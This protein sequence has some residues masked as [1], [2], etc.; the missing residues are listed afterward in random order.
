MDFYGINLKADVTADGT[1]DVGTALSPLGTIYGEVTAAQWGDLAE[2]YT[3]KEEC[4][5]GTVICVSRDP[6]FDVE[7][8]NDELS[9]SVIGAISTKPG[10]IMNSSL[11]GEFVALTGR[12][13]VKVIGPIYKGD[14]IVA[15]GNGC[16]RAGVLSDELVYKIGVAN[17]TNSDTGIKLVECV[18]K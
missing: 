17:E 15:A 14:F 11:V 1:P 4:E 7:P 3:C 13:P 6:K 16:A 10:L 8:C 9:M 18:I 12:L 2:K 5:P